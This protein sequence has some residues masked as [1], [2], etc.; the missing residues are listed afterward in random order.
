[1]LQHANWHS[2]KGCDGAAIR[3]DQ[4]M[5]EGSR[6]RVDGSKGIQGFQ[7]NGPHMCT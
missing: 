6:G 1:M 4:E 3:G 2:F 5:K 7:L